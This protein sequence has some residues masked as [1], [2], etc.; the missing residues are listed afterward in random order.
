MNSPLHTAR[1]NALAYLYDHA[2]DFP[3]WICSLTKDQMQDI[4]EILVQWDAAGCVSYF[5]SM[6]E[7]EKRELLRAVA[8]C[9]GN[10]ADAAR[11]LKVGKTSLYRKMQLWNVQASDRIA[12][13]QASALV[14]LQPNSSP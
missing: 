12:V 7:I 11:L 5:R 8:F 13:Q 6:E 3:Q 2:R 10:I 9:K 4:A 1:M 14:R